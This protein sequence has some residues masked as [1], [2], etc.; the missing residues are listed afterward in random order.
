MSNDNPFAMHDGEPAR[1]KRPDV[2]IFGNG[3]VCKTDTIGFA[4]P[5][6]KSIFELVV[7]ASAGFIPLWEREVILRWRFQEQSLRRF[8]DPA[9]AKSEIRALLGEAL[10]A[11]GEACP[12]R[13]AE[14]SE[15]W[16]FEIAVRNGDDCSAAGCV[17]A[18]SFFPD[19]GQHELLIYPKMFTQVREEQVET[20]I[21]EL[22]HVFG[23]RHF[24]A[25]VRETG[26]PSELF[27]HQDTF[28]IMNYGADSRLTDADR[29]D[30]KTLYRQ[31]WSGQLTNINGTQIR[32]MK[33]FS[34]NRP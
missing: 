27:G 9:A 2:H 30:L 20:L 17:L 12:I 13:F 26:F 28:T 25:K 8:R 18:S 5:R 16:D 6:Q 14:K 31:A 33:P 29:A 22:G 7:D 10:Q 4:M 1:E 15:A 32:L 11:W 23:L 24:F 3:H 21:H 19:Q 34:A